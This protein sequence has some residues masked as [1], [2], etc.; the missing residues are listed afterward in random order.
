MVSFALALVAA[1][2]TLAL[3]AWV[4]SRA[5]APPASTASPPKHLPTTLEG[6]V[7]AL[8]Q[9][10][11]AIEAIKLVRERTGLGLRAAKEAVEALQRGEPLPAHPTTPRADHGSFDEA[12]VRRLLSESRVIEAIKLVRTQTGLGL[13][14]AKDLVDELAAKR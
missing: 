8:L 2:A 1:V 6:E 10:E 14:E 12:E 4:R 13:K 3:V 9:A 11:R 7:R 5:S